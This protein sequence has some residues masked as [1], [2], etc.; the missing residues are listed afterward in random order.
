MI[1]PHP[2]PPPPLSIA[3][4]IDL[5]ILKISMNRKHK[6]DKNILEIKT[7]NKQINEDLFNQLIKIKNIETNTY[8][9]RKRLKAPASVLPKI[10]WHQL[11]IKRN[12]IKNGSRYH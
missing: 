5:Q 9:C 3:L 10:P 6:I 11:N 12:R 7:K 4:Q 1:V 2:P 8:L